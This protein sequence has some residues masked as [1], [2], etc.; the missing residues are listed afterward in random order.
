MSDFDFDSWCELAERDPEAFF[1]AR[2]RAI[3]HLID[4]YPPGQREYLRAMQRHIDCV[5][6]CA[7]TPAKA[8]CCLA[9]MMQERL[10]ALQHQNEVLRA[11]AVK[12]RHRVGVDEVPG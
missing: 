1:R 11:L 7:G 5:R 4:S 8:L 6:V 10:V 2:R 9:V 3:E 12:L